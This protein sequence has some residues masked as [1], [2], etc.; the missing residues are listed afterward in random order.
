MIAKT[1]PVAYD[2]NTTNI[3]LGLVKRGVDLSATTQIESAIVEI[4]GVTKTY[5]YNV[6][7]D[8]YKI[9]F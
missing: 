5:P 4:N 6:I 9:P 2:D 1:T 7:L 3:D 8:H